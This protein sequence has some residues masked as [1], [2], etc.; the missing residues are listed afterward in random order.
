MTIGKIWRHHLRNDWGLSHLIAEVDEKKRAGARM[1]IALV[2]GFVARGRILDEKLSAFVQEFQAL[3]ADFHDLE[4]TDFPPST[5]ALVENNLK[6]L[7]RRGSWAP[8]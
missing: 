6:G 3:R 1:A 2:S 8:R 5:W 7:L 4:K